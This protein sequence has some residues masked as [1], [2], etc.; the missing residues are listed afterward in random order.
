MREGRQDTVSVAIRVGRELA[1]AG[2]AT[3]LSRVASIRHGVV[4]LGLLAFAVTW[5]GLLAYTSLSP[6]VDDLEQLTWVRSLE[7]GYYKHP[8]LPTWLLW[9]PVRLFGWSEWTV[10]AMGAATTLASLAVFWRLMARLR[11]ER[12]AL[13]ALLAAACITY[14]NGRLYYYNHNVV[15]LLAS[16][17]S[18]ALCWQA[19]SARRLRWWAAL[20]ISIGLGAL[21]K[22]QVAVT[23]GCVIAFA[24]HQRAWRDPLH[25]TGMVLAS[26]IA[27]LL[28]APHIEWLFSHD[29]GPVR[30][31]LSSSLG[32]RLGP[33]TRIVE[34][35]HWLADQ[36]LNRALPALVLLGVVAWAIRRTRKRVTPASA[37]RADAVEHARARALLLSWGLVPLGFMPLVGILLGADLQLHW[38][39]PFLLFLIPA[40]MEL[41]PGV[42]WFRIDARTLV[43]TFIVIQ[44]LLL[45][46][47]YLTSPRGPRALHDNHWRNF[48]SRR[49]ADA[50]GTPARRNLGG[51][52]KLLIGP[53]SIAG[54]VALNLPEHPLVLI[55]GRI[56][57]SPWV[58]ARMLASCGAVELGPSPNLQRGI[59]IGPTLPGWSWRVVMSEVDSRTRCEAGPPAPYSLH[60]PRGK[61]T[62]ISSP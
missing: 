47:S 17:V 30:Y 13:L 25:R 54:A 21:A 8:P 14:Y 50:I 24:V 34:S 57:R 9:V 40:V 15:L 51:P 39:T 49:I 42:S 2:S 46:L 62:T 35:A 10:Y 45:A 58:T 32:A 28:V 3:P 52:V 7:W 59:P 37:H 48:D 33:A 20:G 27:L 44:V 26:A 29:F 22:Y 5:V 55:D 60:R 56:D 53:A 4:A 11:G 12:P 23:V 18:A 36:V 1:A 38:G 6:P 61:T 16:T 43:S 41:A 19:F 31:A